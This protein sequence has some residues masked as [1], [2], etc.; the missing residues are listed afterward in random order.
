MSAVS[1]CNDFGAPQN[2]VSYCFHCFP[3]YLTWS[4]GTVHPKGNQSW[5]FIG[6]IDAEAETPVLWPPDTKN[7]PIGK[8]PDAVKV[9]R[10]K[11]KPMS[12][13]EMVEWHDRLRWT[14]VWAS[15]MSWRWTGKPGVLHSMGLQRVGHDW[16]TEL[17]LLYHHMFEVR[18]SQAVQEL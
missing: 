3:I 8:D 11:E 14:W 18:K 15:S 6:R 4:D 13:D 5:M 2:K 7:W 17:M 10:Q 9:L 16:A 12:E 1:L